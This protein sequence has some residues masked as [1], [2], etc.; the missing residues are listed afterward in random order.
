MT[1]GIELF[2]GAWR[3]NAPD[4][5]IEDAPE[6]LGRGKRHEFRTILEAA[7]LNHPMKDFG[8]KPR[9]DLREVGRIQ[10]AVEQ[11]P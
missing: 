8:L 3:A 1:I 4:I 9:D 6:L 5:E 10:Q 7:G 11:R 2:V